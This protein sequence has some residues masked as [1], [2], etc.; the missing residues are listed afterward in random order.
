MD[1]IP[2]PNQ[3]HIYSTESPKTQ[4]R[5]YYSNPIGVGGCHILYYVNEQDDELSLDLIISDDADAYQKLKEHSDE[6]ETELG[7]EVHWGELRENHAGKMRSNLG[8]KR[9]VRIEDQDRWEES[10]DWM[11]DQ[12]A[13]FHEVFPERLR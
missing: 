13:R 9:E 3:K 6:I 7:S 2:R 1:S 12:G 10:F 11:L 4:P 5:Y 8:V